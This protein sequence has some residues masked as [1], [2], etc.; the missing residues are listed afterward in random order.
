MLISRCEKLLWVFWGPRLGVLVSTLTRGGRKSDLCLQVRIPGLSERKLPGPRLSA[1][2]KS[3]S[4]LLSTT[5]LSSIQRKKKK[6]KIN[7]HVDHGRTHIQT[8][9]TP[10][11]PPSPLPLPVSVTQKFRLGNTGRQTVS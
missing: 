1:G 8:P 5:L 11:S 4:G 10:I 6:K 2:G 7:A 3:R 9:T